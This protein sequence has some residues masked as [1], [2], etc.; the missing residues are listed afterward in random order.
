MCNDKER[1]LKKIKQIKRYRISTEVVRFANSYVNYFNHFNKDLQPSLILRIERDY[2]VTVT[3]RQ[4]NWKRWMLYIEG[5][6]M[7]TSEKESSLL[8]EYEEWNKVNRNIKEGSHHI[9]IPLPFETQR[10]LLTEA[11]F[12]KIKVVRQGSKDAVYCACI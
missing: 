11:G 8:L 6:Y 4:T 2:G 12:S 3:L 7:V 5:D 1:I 10:R 9:D